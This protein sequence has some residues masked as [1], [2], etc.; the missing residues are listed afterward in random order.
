MASYF[1]FKTRLG[2]NFKIQFH[3]QVWSH[4]GLEIKITCQIYKHIYKGVCKIKIRADLFFNIYNCCYIKF[5]VE[6]KI[7]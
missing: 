3:I 1:Y 4:R 2:E 5:I 6:F 7:R